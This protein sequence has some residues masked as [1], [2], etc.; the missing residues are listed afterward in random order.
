MCIDKHTAIA[1]KRFSVPGI[2][3]LLASAGV[4]ALKSCSQ[5][6]RMSFMQCQ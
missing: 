2:S 5:K 1:V 3:L 4:H 6:Q